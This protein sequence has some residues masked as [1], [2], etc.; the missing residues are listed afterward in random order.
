MLSVK[1]LQEQYTGIFDAHSYFLRDVLQY[2]KGNKIII[3]ELL[4]A[5]TS[6]NYKAHPVMEGSGAILTA[7]DTSNVHLNL[8]MYVLHECFFFFS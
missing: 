1:S 8:C 4:R 5:K 3:D 6:Y 7:W 2:A